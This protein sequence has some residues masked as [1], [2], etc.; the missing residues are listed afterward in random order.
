MLITYCVIP[1]NNKAFFEKSKSSPWIDADSYCSA[2]MFSQWMSYREPATI[3]SATLL[4]RQIRSRYNPNNNHL[5]WQGFQATPPLPHKPPT[6]T[7]SNDRLPS[8]QRQQ[9]FQISLTKCHRCGRRQS[10]SAALGF[11]IQIS[12]LDS[13]LC[14]SGA[15]FTLWLAGLPPPWLFV[16]YGSVERTEASGQE[17]SWASARRPVVGFCWICLWSLVKRSEGFA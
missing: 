8:S 7:P 11:V 16:C 3:I 2:Y 5:R 10:G 9:T 17:G 6:S 15:V 4:H 12:K 13:R 14:R 1:W